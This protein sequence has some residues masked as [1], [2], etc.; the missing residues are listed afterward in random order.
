MIAHIVGS[1]APLL[2]YSTGASGSIRPVTTTL[3]HLVFRQPTT[4]E[5][6]IAQAN[7]FNLYP[8]GV[9][10]G[11]TG[12]RE[13]FWKPWDPDELTWEVRLGDGVWFDPAGASAEDSYNGVVVTYRLP[14]GT[15][16]VAGPTGS[17]FDV[18]DDTL[19]DT[20]PAN[21][22]N[23]HGIPKR[24]ALLDISDVTTDAGATTV[25]AIYLQERSQAPRRGTLRVT[26][27]QAIHPTAGSRPAWAIKAGDHVS[28]TDHPVS[29]PRRIIE[30]DY[31]HDTRTNTLTV[32][33]SSQRL[34]AILERM[35]VSLVGVI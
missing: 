9:Y 25:G 13:F 6:A 17:G 22:V 35:G 31:D 1:S 2:T 7:K 16:R 8:W 21:P 34:D 3:P 10:A 12:P 30:T 26:T 24:W 27:G 18:T 28:I 29:E 11:P 19:I 20:D 15:E 23:A 4:G 33:N 32:D 14:D 5:D